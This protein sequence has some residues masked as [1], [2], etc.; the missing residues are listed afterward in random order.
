MAHDDHS[1]RLRR[2][3]VGFDGSEGGRDAVTLAATLA[4]PDAEFVLV[5]V[6]PPVGIFTMLSEIAEDE[7]FDLIA[8]GHCYPG[9]VGRALMGSTGQ[10]L[11]HGA[12]APIA[13]APR[14]YADLPPAPI[15]TIVVAWD[16][17]PEAR[18]ALAHAEALARREG[19][20]LRLVTIE[21]ETPSLPG[22]VGWEP[23]GRQ[24]PD[25]VLA[26]GIE[27]VGADVKVDGRCIDGGSIAAEIAEFCAQGVDLVVVG[28]RGY[29]TLGRVLVGSVANGLLHRASCPVLVVP[30]PALAPGES[31]PRAA[32]AIGAGR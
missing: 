1:L 2:V 19:A 10:G 7:A 18:E 24:T 5:D 26:A 11:A 22:M 28:S 14:L 12:T 4:E 6:I 16:G 9:A 23:T 25:E 31:D 17:G 29:G 30:R 21:V 8:I 27:A 3:L 32:V 13:A 15:R 20:R